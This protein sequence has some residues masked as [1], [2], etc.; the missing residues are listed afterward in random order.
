MSDTLIGHSIN[1]QPWVQV[2][3]TEE[4]YLRHHRYSAGEILLLPPTHV[5]ALVAQGR[6]ILLPEPPSPGLG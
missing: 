5:Q 4:V 3:L 6:A 2:Q 1:R